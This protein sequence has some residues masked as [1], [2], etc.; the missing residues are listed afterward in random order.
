MAALPYWE[1]PVGNPLCAFATAHP[2]FP[3]PATFLPTINVEPIKPRFQ[4]GRKGLAMAKIRII[5][6]FCQRK[7]QYEDRHDGHK[8]KCP[9]CRGVVVNPSIPA[10]G[11][12]KRGISSRRGPLRGW[13]GKLALAGAM[14]LFL[15]AALWGWWLLNPV[16]LHWPDRRPIGALFLASNYHSSATN[17]RGW[18]ND[19]KLNVTGTNGA[20]VFHQALREYTDHSIEVLKRIGA[21]GVIV[22]DLEGEQYPHKTSFIGDPRLL[23]QLAPEMA[24]VVDE[25]FQRLRN[26][27]F[28]VGVT[29]RPQQLVFDERGLPRQTF[30][31]NVKRLLLDKIDYAR[32]RWQAS[33]FY[34]DS[35]DG[36]WRPDEL[37]QLRSVAGERPDILLMPEHTWLPYWSF[38]RR[39]T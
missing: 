7:L 24:P 16:K 32:S 11:A 34:V 10:A 3:L 19:P 1:S 21:Q 33:L 39:R 13:R 27:G 23:D 14:F 6:P 4:P 9:H 22:W 25:F 18:F 20:E 35:N 2:V 30:R 5:C 36:I 15:V 26:A 28:R 17:P 29:I 8:L 31:L 38:L 37:W 12:R